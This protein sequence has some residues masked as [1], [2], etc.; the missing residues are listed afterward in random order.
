MKL[1]FK[2]RRFLFAASLTALIFAFA[3]CSG[4][5]GSPEDTEPVST[6]PTYETVDPADFFRKTTSEETTAVPETEP[7]QESSD[8]VETVQ[9]PA[10]E[11]ETE[12]EAKTE[13]ETEPAESSVDETHE[14][15]NKSEPERDYVLNTNTMKFHYPSC[16][17]VEDIKDYNR[18]DFHGTRE[19]VIARGFDPCGR[20]KP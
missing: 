4:Y 14:T 15:E 20:C 2:S 16:N 10:T 9:E 6:R 12:T 7:A 1:L 11:A 13:A 19:E 8:E 5:S 17:S 18:E 3:G